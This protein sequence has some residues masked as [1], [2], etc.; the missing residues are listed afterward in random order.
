M[1]KIDLSVIVPMHNEAE[2]ISE[3]IAA[4]V[5]ELEP[6]GIEWEIILVND[7]STDETLKK[8][9]EAAGAERRIR[10]V[11]YAINRGR[12]YA[13]RSGFSR[14]SGDIVI[15]IDA[16]LT[17]TADHITKIYKEFSRGHVDIVIGS[18]YMAGGSTVQVPF[19]RLLISRIGNI[20]LSLTLPGKIKTITGI[21]RGY[22][23]EVLDA[24]EIESDGKEIHLE[25]LSK[26]ISLGYRVRE[27][28][29]V[30]LGRTLGK[31]KF[32]FKT[33]SITH[34]LFSLYQKPMLLF[35]LLGVLMLAGSAVLGVVFLVHSYRGILEPLRPMFILMFLLF[36][37]G[38]QMFSFGFVSNQFGYL[39]KEIYRIQKQNRRLEDKVRKDT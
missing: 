18:P 25:I 8:C 19:K 9:E 22:R 13:L 29:A 32:R 33:T 26:A 15:S 3:T 16:D 31:S 28:P 20:I 36:F 39:K 12:G 2:T 11:S 21:L 37:M 5:G 34:L 14:A 4:I 7:G 30:L 6:L 38:I 24:L 35:G 23:K 10:L 17:Y 27:I 1:K